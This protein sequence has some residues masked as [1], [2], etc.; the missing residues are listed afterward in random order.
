[1]RLVRTL[2][3]LVAVWP[4]GRAEEIALAGGGSEPVARLEAHGLAVAMLPG[5]GGKIISLKGSDGHEWLSRSGRPYRA[6]AGLAGF[7]DGEFDGADEI[8]PTMDACDG[9]PA[10]GEAWRLAWKACDGPGLSYVLEG[11]LRPYRL[12]RSITIEPGAVQLAYVLQ[13]RGDT[14]LRYTYLFHPLFS[15]AE[16][17]RMELPEAQP[18]VVTNAQHNFLPKS[19]KPVPWSSLVDGPFATATASMAAKRFWSLAVSPAP[20]F[21]RLRRP[22]GASLTMTWDA[23]ALPHLAVWSCEASPFVGDLA[24][25]AP[26]PASGPTSKLSSAI[27][28]GT[29]ATVP[30]GGERR[31]SI[32]LAF[33]PR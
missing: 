13:N 8:F 11:G 5:L 3:I 18:V 32:R 15:I 20:A 28:D 33:A 1:M 14:E 22:G 12:Q 2:A 30:A 16:P 24:H 27:A 31:W 26:E 25:F 10:H 9:L 29:A 7:G 6:R 17:L 4:L 21:V 19:G 23:A